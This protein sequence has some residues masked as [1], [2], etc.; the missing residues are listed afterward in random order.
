MHVV[1][2]VGFAA[3]PH[4]ATLWVLV[5]VVE[6]VGVA[7]LQRCSVMWVLALV[8]KQGPATPCCESAA[9]VKRMDAR[10]HTAGLVKVAFQLFA[11]CN[12]LVLQLHHFSR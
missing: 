5:Q 6:L 8:M 9:A 2:L 3:L 4:C 10:G 11:D 7:A 1:S 12:V